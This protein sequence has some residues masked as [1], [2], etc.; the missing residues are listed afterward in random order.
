METCS[1]TLPVLFKHLGLPNSAIA[2]AEFCATHPLPAG[3]ALADAP[4]WTAA[5]AQFIDEAWQQDADWIPE[6]DRLAARL[7][8]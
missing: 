6:I 1:H 2:I 5:Q 3:T 8:H 4:F 7:R